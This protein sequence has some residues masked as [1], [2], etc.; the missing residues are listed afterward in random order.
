LPPTVVA[1]SRV[2]QMSG[3]LTDRETLDKLLAPNGCTRVT[4]IQLAALLSGYAES[5]F[6]LGMKVNLQG[7]I[8]VMEAMRAVGKQLGSPQIYVFTS[9]D[10]VASYNE[11]NKATPVSE[12]AYCLSPV[13]YGI[14]KACV[15]MLL[16]DYS[17][18]GFI[19]GRVGRLSAVL[20]RPGWSNSISWSFTGIFTQTL[21]GKDFEVPG[22]LPMD[23]T[24]PCSC[25]QNN[26][27]GLLCLAGSVD[28]EKLGHNRVVQVPAR[29][30]SLNM[31]WKAC[32]AVAE[33]EGVG[34]SLGKLTMGELPKNATVKELNVCP[35]V[36]H[37][38]AISL[39]L[40]D[41]VRI[42]EIIRDY[43]IRHVAQVDG[44]AAKKARVGA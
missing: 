1:D 16:C 2:S 22:S 6:D 5:D 15:E 23:R 9:T 28:A 35:A 33:E 14:Q 38:K 34:A 39:G 31:I 36:D 20:G 43:Y 8:G 7:A 29:S 19:D 3:D 25:V 30:L 44:P 40:P 21:A 24:L 32:Q 11:A 41:E 13:S 42:K 37:S 4:C 18:K 10:Y 26:V 17:R 27:D 12:E